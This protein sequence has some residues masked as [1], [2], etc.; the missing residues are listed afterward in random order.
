M[1]MFEDFSEF[2]IATAG[3]ANE[4]N[5]FHW[6]LTFHA[7]HRLK[8]FICWQLNLKAGPKVFFLKV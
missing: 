6:R 5:F 4:T 8:Y 7:F 2:D 1:E 3:V